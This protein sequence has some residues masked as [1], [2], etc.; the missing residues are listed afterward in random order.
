MSAMTIAEVIA[1][2]ALMYLL[3]SLLCTIINEWI[4]QT[5]R[6]RSRNLENG[7]KQLLEDLS[8]SGLAKDIYEH[9]L[10][11]KL[12]PKRG[13]PSYLSGET[14][15]RA[16]LDVLDPNAKNIADAAKAVESVKNSIQNAGIPEGVKKAVLA[17]IDQSTDDLDKLRQS[18]QL[19]FD[20][21]MDRISGWYKRRIRLLSLGVG[22][23]VAI[24]FNA[25]TLRIGDRLW[26]DPDLRVAV[27]DL[28][29][30]AA[31]GCEGVERV[32]DCPQLDKFEKLQTEL[33]AFPIGWQ[34]SNRPDGAS[35]FFLM[36]F[37]CVITGLAISLGAP[38][39][40]D[41]LNKLNSIR[42]SGVKPARSDGVRKM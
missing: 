20:N 36:L 4:A 16:F 8:A 14:F 42:A 37:G 21:A 5:L 13:R 40:F 27:A 28:A 34:S 23:L 12:E 24:S 39:W 30:S 9:P 26:K 6:L 15:A 17:L 22:I 29:S 35:D 10:V 18:V 38:F 19:W 2:L 11:K 41:V 25:D 32:S 1:G 33:R 7:I 3:L 31:K